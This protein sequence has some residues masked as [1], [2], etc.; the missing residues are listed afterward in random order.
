MH[1]SL[2]FEPHTDIIAKG[3]REV[4][5]GHKINLAT[6]KSN[7][8][9]DVVIEKGNPADSERFI[10]LLK[11]QKNI[12][13]CYPERTATDGGYASLSNVMQA[14][15]LGVKEVAFHKKR[16]ISIEEEANGCIDN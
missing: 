4:T 7:L 14:K 5:F 10:P 12:Y 9:L 3:N 8:V 1:L 2:V 13:Q 6:G 11:R 15:S 16:G